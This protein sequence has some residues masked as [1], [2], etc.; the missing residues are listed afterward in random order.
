MRN[1]TFTFTAA[2]LRVFDAGKAGR[3]AL[4]ESAR[5]AADLANAELVDQAARKLV[6]RAFRIDAAAAGM[7]DERRSL[8]IELIRRTIAELNAQAAARE[9]TGEPARGTSAADR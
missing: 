9:A 6:Q 2:A 4:W 8:D 5:S 1:R 3:D 7:P